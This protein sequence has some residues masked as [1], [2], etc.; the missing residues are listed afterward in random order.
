MTRFIKRNCSVTDA[1]QR[2]QK[3]V[4][5]GY[6]VNTDIPVEMRNKSRPGEYRAKSLS[7]YNPLS[8]VEAILNGM[9]QNYWNKTETYEALAEYIRMDFDGLKETVALLM[10]GGRVVLDILTYQNDMTSFHGR[11]DVLTMLIHLGYLGYDVD[12]K[13]VFIPNHE[14]L[15]EFKTS[16]KSEEWIGTFTTLKK[17]QELL[18]ATWD[19]KEEREASSSNRIKI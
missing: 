6:F 4:S 18:K 7:V 5:R 19:K 15:D 16:T 3:N 12:T 8:V 11:D 1:L 10:D 9:I 17:S 13:E 14:I 2:L